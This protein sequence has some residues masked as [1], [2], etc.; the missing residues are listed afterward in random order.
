ML[1]KNA[2]SSRAIPVA[3]RIEAVRKDPFVPVF[4]GANK[5]GMQ[6]TSAVEV[7]EEEKAKAIWLDACNYVLDKASELNALGIHK[8]LSNRIFESFSHVSQLITGTEWANFFNLRV[9]A[10]AQPEFF[11]LAGMMLEA[12]V[13]SEPVQLLPGEWHVPFGDQT[14]GLSLEDRLKVSAARCARLSYENHNGDFSIEADIKLAELL[15]ELGH[16]S[17]VEHTAQAFDPLTV[18]QTNL[19]SWLKENNALYDGNDIWW[20]NFRN[21]RQYRKTLS[22]ENQSTFDPQVLLER[23]HHTQAF[24]GIS[25]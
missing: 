7:A 23:Y 8:Q 2:A 18:E 21:W 1:S 5:S 10:A 22:N 25:V 6:A 19:S 14:E 17:P 4:W 9:H 12:Y 20:A 15:Q 11:T 16:N 3:R 24:R 13:A